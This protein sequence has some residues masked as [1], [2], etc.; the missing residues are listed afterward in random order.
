MVGA[1]GSASIMVWRTGCCRI[2]PAGC[3]RRLFNLERAPCIMLK[4]AG[5][6]RLE[7]I[8]YIGERLND[9]Y[10]TQYRAP[11]YADMASGRVDASVVVENVGAGRMS[12]RI[13]HHPPLPALDRSSHCGAP[14]ISGS[15][16]AL[17]LD[18]A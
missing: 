10:C 2:C 6:H 18:A 15:G 4:R 3:C 13:L 7:V 17:R 9:F 16:C 8:S 12:A 1:L 5:G 11:L 14:E